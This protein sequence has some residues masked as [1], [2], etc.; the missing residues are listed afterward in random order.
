[1]TCDDAGNDMVS[2][3]YFIALHLGGSRKT[4]RWS[5]PAAGTI[6]KPC[7]KP[8]HL[9]DLGALY[10]CCY[11]TQ[12]QRSPPSPISPFYGHC[13]RLG[14]CISFAPPPPSIRSNSLQSSQFPWFTRPRWPA[15]T[16][17]CILFIIRREQQE[18][19]T[20]FQF[21]LPP[22]YDHVLCR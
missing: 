3:I 22:T 4:Y 14:P 5:V 20:P 16:C 10:T 2:I 17:C 15:L 12:D 7:C 9:L 11:A 18:Q 13:L 6:S 19:P 21:K 8:S 1:M